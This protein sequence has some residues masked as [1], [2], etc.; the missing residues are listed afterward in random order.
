MRRALLA[1]AVAAG[2]LAGAAA[3][4]PGRGL[5]TAEAQVL[6]IEAIGAG[7]PDLAEAV[8]RAL[9]AADPADPFAQFL[10]ARALYERGAMAGARTAGARAF[11]IARSGQQRFQSAHLAAQ[12]AGAEGRFTAA[13]WWLRRAAAAAPAEVQRAQ[14]LHELRIARRLAPLGFGGSV[15]VTPSDNVNDGATGAFNIIDGVPLVGELSADGQA[16]SGTVTQVQG[17]LRWRIAEAAEHATHL[18]LSASLREV[19]LSRDARAAAPSADA[20]RLDSARLDLSLRHVREI[21][22]TGWSIAGTVA[23]GFQQSGTGDPYGFGRMGAEIA[24]K[25]GEDTEL[26]LGAA[27]EYRDRPGHDRVDSLHLTVTQRLP[28]NHML[29]ATAYATGHDTG[30]DWSRSSG[31]G[32]QLGLALGQPVGPVS[33]EVGVG[34]GRS[35]FPDYRVGLIPVP[36]GRTD[37]SASVTLD[38]TF[39]GASVA[40]FAPRVTVSHVATRSN[41]SRFETRRTGVGFGIETVF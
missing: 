30:T 9:V 36:G 24:G 6:G 7:R 4:E 3:A 39:P 15:S 5:T 1:G 27:V 25:A 21:P 20:D 37:R 32:A 40:G 23:V 16:L 22:V 10:L 33:V 14:A 18:G 29:T 38:L 8:A 34:Y 17:R 26:S 2:L 13:Q 19:T 12:A 35:A 31:H 28:G 41:V 11:R